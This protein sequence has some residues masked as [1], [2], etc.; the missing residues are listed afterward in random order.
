[1][2]FVGKGVDRIGHV[3]AD[4]PRPDSIRYEQSDY[5]DNFV[6]AETGTTRVGDGRHRQRGMDPPG[7]WPSRLVASGQ[8]RERRRRWC[9]L[10]RSQDQVAIAWAEA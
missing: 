8:L 10:L 7:H 6:I 5:N 2:P 3:C 1:M 9:A 4:G